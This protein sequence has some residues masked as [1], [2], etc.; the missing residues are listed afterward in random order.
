[1]TRK[2]TMPSKFMLEFV[3]HI[4]V[5]GGIVKDENGF[6]APV[7]EPGWTDL[8]RLYLDICEFLGRKPRIEEWGGG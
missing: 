5:T 1:M 2:S 8:G 3:E 6:Y 7:A 4:E